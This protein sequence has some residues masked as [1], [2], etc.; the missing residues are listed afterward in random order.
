MVCESYLDR[1]AVVQLHP[2]ALKTAV[3]AG[4]SAQADRGEEAQP[5]EDLQIV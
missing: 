1:I 3:Q 5:G 4:G 2:S